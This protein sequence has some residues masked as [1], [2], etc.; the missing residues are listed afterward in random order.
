ALYATTLSA[1]AF[2]LLHTT[3]TPHWTRYRALYPPIGLSEAWYLKSDS[4]Y[5]LPYLR[6]AP[7]KC[8]PHKRYGPGARVSTYEF[9]MSHPFQTWYDFGD[10]T[11][12]ERE[13]EV[14]DSEIDL[15][16]Y[17]VEGWDKDWEESFWGVERE[18]KTE[19]HRDAA[20]GQGDEEGIGE[21]PEIEHKQSI[22]PEVGEYRVV[23]IEGQAAPTKPKNI[24]NPEPSATFTSS[25]LTAESLPGSESPLPVVPK[26][27]LG[28]LDLEFEQKRTPPKEEKTTLK[29][30]RDVSINLSE[31]DNEMPARPRK[32]RKRSSVNGSGDDNKS[33]SD[34]APLPARARR[35]TR[36]FKTPVAPK[37]KQEISRADSKL[38]FSADESESAIDSRGSDSDDGF[39]PSP[40]KP[41]S[42]AKP[43]SRSKARKK[44][45][46]RSNNLQPGPGATARRAIFKVKVRSQEEK[47]AILL[48][49]KRERPN[50]NWDYP[51]YLALA[52]LEHHFGLERKVPQG[53]RD[54]E[55]VFSL[56]FRDDLALCKKKAGAKN[57]V[58]AIYNTYGAKDRSG[59][60]HRWDLVQAALEAPEH[61][62]SDEYKELRQKV[63]DA[64]AQLGIQ[65]RLP[66]GQTKAVDFEKID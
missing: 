54:G 47:N 37:S 46:S 17:L 43:A 1:H 30:A 44:L 15:G 12:Q 35:L 27:D 28:D 3:T 4:I 16:D 39:I 49:P 41:V 11:V 64:V 34:S 19:E 21:H 53:M 2:N 36:S 10:V 65:S 32:K 8:I 33:D 40:P 57:W 66:P 25:I 6:A 62:K 58:D 22:E 29:H 24:L 38:N 5:R 14:S 7:K 31:D 18:E 23:G 55:R 9:K 45:P 13:Q 48:Q 56:L 51:H 50:F 42:K 20:F 60:A 61:A 26:Q 52:L 63:F 59:K